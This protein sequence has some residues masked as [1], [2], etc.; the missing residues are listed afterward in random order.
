MYSLRAIILAKQVIRDNQI[1]ILMFTLEYGKITV[2]GK[3]GTYADI[4]T[5]V[6]VLIE[7]K[8]QENTIS[9]MTLLSV[10]KN[11]DWDY[12]ATIEYLSLFKLIKECLPEWYE[13][14]VLYKDLVELI[15]YLSK[16]SSKWET[17]NVWII[18]LFILMKARVLK[19]L[20][21]LNEWFFK[22]SRNL[23]VIYDRLEVASM[24]SMISARLLEWNTISQIDLAIQ[25]GIHTYQHRT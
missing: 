20:W 12:R 18:Q 4:W 21:F 16:N 11:D 6:E 24:K 22:N 17:S 14:K 15:E 23:T 1:R 25:D 3:K 2:W 7:R 19:K 5:M 10:P 8:K 9:G 13:Q